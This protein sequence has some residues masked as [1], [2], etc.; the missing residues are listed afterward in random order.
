MKL[1]KIFILLMGLGLPLMSYAADDL[2]TLGVVVRMSYVDM[3]AM[4]GK[5]EDTPE[6][7][8]IQGQEDQHY[9]V[10]KL[11]SQPFLTGLVASLK[12]PSSTPYKFHKES[13]WVIGQQNVPA[14]V[15]LDPSGTLYLYSVPNVPNKDDFKG[16]Q[17]LPFDV[18]WSQFA[19][20]PGKYG[21]EEVVPS[22]T[23]CTIFALKFDRRDVYEGAS[24]GS[25][26]AEGSSGDDVLSLSSD[27][28]VA[29][30]A[31]VDESVSA[32]KLSIDVPSHGNDS[33][34]EEF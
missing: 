16:G 5:I 24:S 12:N 19:Y 10:R 1:S 20:H 11:P 34:Y 13:W 9:P 27:D 4:Q 14:L 21:K 30:V 23:L 15:D 32:E 2:N 8:S 28:A 3:M 6:E 33:G 26:S 17:I 18:F 25:G 31:P 7:F 22:D 29:A